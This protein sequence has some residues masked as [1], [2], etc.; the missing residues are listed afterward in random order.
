[1][2]PDAF[3]ADVLA[4]LARAHGTPLY[5]YDSDTVLARLAQLAPFD[6]VRYAQKANSNLALLALLRKAGAH[7]DAVSA[8]EIERA[9]AAGYRPEDIVYTADVFDAAALERVVSLGLHVNAGSP[10]MLP[11]LAEARPGANVTIRV[12]PGFGEGRDRRVTTG[13]KWT[14]HGIWHA[15]LAQVARAVERLGLRVTG[16]HVHVGSNGRLERLEQTTAA[17][18][19]A[20]R[21]VPE[22]LDTISAGGGLPVPYRDDEA[23]PDIGRYAAAWTEARA[24]LSEALDRP[25]RLETEPGRFLVAE[26]GVLLTTVLGTKRADDVDYVL[27]DAGFHTFAR[28]AMYGAYHGITAVG[29]EGAPESPKVVAGPLCES[30]D[31]LT[32][33]ESAFSVPRELPDVEAGDLL[34]IHDAGAYGATMASNYNSRELPAEVLVANGEARLVRRRQT[35]DELM[36]QERELS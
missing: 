8:G 28:P 17:L 34:C 13:G 26:A 16:L 3:T 19:A 10:D 20:A 36:A 29:K 14:K 25:L 12:N 35:L 7:A 24:A 30:T 33:D 32:Q 9:L 21:A 31:L 18:V 23:A 6:V 5:V 11:V 15:D 1:M 2:K 27:V 4:D 22:Q